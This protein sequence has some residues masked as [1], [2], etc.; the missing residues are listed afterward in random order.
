MLGVLEIHSTH[1][2]G[3]WWGEQSAVERDE[4]SEP[5]S[6]TWKTCPGGRTSSLP[7][8]PAST[9]TLPFLSHEKGRGRPLSSGLSGGRFW[10]VVAL[11]QPCSC[12]EI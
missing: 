9:C 7:I 3:C 12:Q 6:S 4:F 2:H 1:S 5:L 8:P 11:R 10:S